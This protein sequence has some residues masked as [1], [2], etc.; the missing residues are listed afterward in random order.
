M[1]VRKIEWKRGDPR[2]LIVLAARPHDDIGRRRLGG[3]STVVSFLAVGGLLEEADDVV[4]DTTQIALTVG[5]NDTKQTLSSFLGQVRLLENTLG[6]VNVRQIE[7][8]TRMARVKDGCQ[9]HTGLQRSN[10]DTMHL[11]ISDV[12]C[13]PEVDGIDNLVIAIV[14]IAIKILGL[15]TMAC[16]VTSYQ[17]I[18]ASVGQCRVPLN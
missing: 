11:I 18:V 17:Y 15:S 8:G 2:G 3:N 6:R 10:H 12:A 1:V 9:T 4:G 16:G 13:L 7:G 5:G 14:L